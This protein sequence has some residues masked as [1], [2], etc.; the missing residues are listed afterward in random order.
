MKNNMIMLTI[1]P[2][3]DQSQEKHSYAYVNYSEY[4]PVK[5]T[6][7]TVKTTTTKTQQN[8]QTKNPN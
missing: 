7:K 1:G 6:I 8:S 3:K 4:G 5:T 2:R